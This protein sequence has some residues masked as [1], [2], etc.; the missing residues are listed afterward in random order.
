[1]FQL[2]N[3][4]E[5]VA[6][7]EPKFTWEKL[8]N[9]SWH[10]IL[11][12]NIFSISSFGLQS[13]LTVNNFTTSTANSFRLT[14]YNGVGRLTQ[15]YTLKPFGKNIKLRLRKEKYHRRTKDSEVLLLNQI[16]S[17]IFLSSHF[18]TQRDYWFKNRKAGIEQNGINIT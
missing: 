13:N 18:A 8:A 14:V 17:E 2:L 11:N 5:A 9:S 12:D 10:K 6:Y 4:F 1:M 15:N 3:F 16:M 7:P